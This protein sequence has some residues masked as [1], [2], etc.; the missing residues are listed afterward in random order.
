MDLRH[1]CRRVLRHALLLSALLASSIAPVSAQSTQKRI[2]L[3]IGNSNYTQPE[4]RLAG[5]AK[6][7]QNVADTLK[8]LGFTVEL[9][10]D[11]KK[12]ETEQAVA[13][14]RERLD[15]LGSDTVGLMYYA[16]HGGADRASRDNLIVPVD[17]NLK[18][19]EANGVSVRKIQNTLQA[20]GDK[21]RAAGVIVVI[22]A[23]RSLGTG[24]VR[25]DS[26][27]RS[28]PRPMSNIA[29]PDNGFLFAFSTSANQS[30]SDKG[31]FAEILNAQLR[32]RGLTVPQVFEE[33]QKQ[34][35][36][37]TGQLPV[38]QP[39]ITATIC[40][41]T[42]E[43][44]YESRMRAAL[45][46]P[47]YEDI[48]KFPPDGSAASILNQLL[49]DPASL[50]SFSRKFNTPA[51]LDWLRKL[52]AHGFD[53]SRLVTIKD[54]KRS[55]LLAAISAN[56]VPLAI[57]LLD[58][59]AS[60]YVFEE[61]WGQEYSASYFL[62][63]LGMFKELSAS[64]DEK[65]ALA[66]SMV[67]AGL[68]TSSLVAQGDDTRVAA[69]PDLGVSIPSQSRIRVSSNSTICK[70][71]NSAGYDWCAL[72]AKLP[73]RIQLRRGAGWHPQFT[74][75]DLIKPLAVVDDY[76]YVMTYSP[77]GWDPT[78]YGLMRI[79]KNADQLIWYRYGRGGMGLGHCEELRDLPNWRPDGNYVNCWRRQIM[80]R[81]S[82]AGT[83]TDPKYG[84]VIYDAVATI[85]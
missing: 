49:D 3:V 26:A 43:A 65:K 9:R 69:A 62:F 57:T 39:M 54:R 28:T 68:T 71:S 66:E 30:A 56:N 15:G 44:D 20:N 7:A 53:P 82:E 75:A 85:P 33:V 6:D 61:L 22:D 18:D 46:S 64:S 78:G 11:L 4:E 12:G 32:R 55:L 74:Q 5:A 79:S 70:R 27:Q 45:R 29:E 24:P 58:G 35:Y 37:K 52:T 76:L 40:L 60:P 48:T 2:A 47:T 80:I 10:F 50:S 16:G 42:C 81:G 14:F 72:V 84:S 21:G 23:C 1:L 13:R 34:V 51:A 17:S 67:R 38:Y 8:E 36:A 41:V 31:D 77:P 59:G 73:S 19:F 63:P 25:G 83:Y